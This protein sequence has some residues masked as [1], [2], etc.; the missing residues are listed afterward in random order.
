M[1]ADDA[2]VGSSEILV[3]KPKISGQTSFI[4]TGGGVLIVIT[5]RNSMRGLTTVS[6]VERL[7]YLF[8]AG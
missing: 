5:G 6:L 3:G 1:C 7:C 2:F 8:I 4:H